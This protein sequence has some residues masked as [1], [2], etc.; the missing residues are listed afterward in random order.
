MNIIKHIQLYILIFTAFVIPLEVCFSQDTLS[1]PE[2]SASRG[3]YDTAFELVITSDNEDASIIYTLDGSNPLTSQSAYTLSSPAVIDIDPEDET[4]RY[5]APVVIVRACVSMDGYESSGVVTHSYFFLDDIT[6]LSPHEEPPGDQ[7]PDRNM[8]DGEFQFMDYGLDPDVY[9]DP[10]YEDYIQEAFTSVP[11]ISLV[12][13]LENLF[14]PESGI[15]VNA[16][17]RGIDWER[18]VSVELLNPDD[19]P[20]FQIDAGLRMRG[21]WGRRNENPKHAFRLFFRQEYGSGKLNYPL[22]GD[23]GV[24]EFDNVDLRTSQ[25]YSWAAEGSNRNTMVR[26]LFSRDTQRDMEQ[27]YTRTRYYHLYINGVY[28]GLYQTQER[29][30]ASYAASYFGGSSDEYD[31]IKVDVGENTD[32]YEIEATDGNLDAYEQLWEYAS[33]GFDTDEAYYRVLGQNSDGTINPDYEVLVDVDNLADYMICT[34]YVGDGDGPVNGRQWPNNFYGIYNHSNPDG[35]KYFRHDAEHSLFDRNADITVACTGGEEFRHFNPR[36]LHQQLAEHPEYRIRFADRVYKHFFYDGA[37]TPDISIHRLDERISSIEEAI[38]ALS[39][40]W[41]DS[42]SDTPRTRNVD[43]VN[44]L[45]F[46]IEDIFPYR[47]N[48]VLNQFE[49]RG[50]FPR[51]DPPEF[52]RESGIVSPGTELSLESQVGTI[53]CTVDGNDPRLPELADESGRLSPSAIEYN[54]PLEI[55]STM[56]IKARVLSDGNWSALNQV[57]LWVPLGYDNLLITEIHYHPSDRQD[58]NDT[59]LEFIELKNVGDVSLDIGGLTFSEGVDFTFET[60]TQI[61][62]DEYIVLASNPDEFENR[63]AF[64][65]FDEY[66]SQ[67]NN[68]GDTISL[69]YANGDTLLNIIYQDQF[70]WPN[71]ADGDGY[72]LV[73]REESVT[74]DPN[75]PSSWQASASRHGSPG[76]LD[77]EVPLN[78]NSKA[79]PDAFQL[80]Q[81]YPNPFNPATTIHFDVPIQASVEVVIY[82]ILGQKIR[83]LEKAIMSAGSHTMHW[84]GKNDSGMNVTS[85]IYFYRV[86]FENQVLVKKM[87]LLK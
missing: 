38:I 4:G 3:F 11:S 41:G 43:W 29:S 62:A 24:D 84:D 68:G 56:L 23:E 58:V 1:V 49:N 73:L 27:P 37:C 78:K 50:W 54:S 81:N 79:S 30:E 72:S 61:D 28:W 14:D 40:R 20:G 5:T 47:T 6:G 86:K 52:N 12:T 31:V 85:G 59:E 7:W 13:D 65:P 21:G 60:G 82:N 55:N 69:H 42:S 63:Y 66:N 8:D 2:F 9:E 18:Q 16:R 25:N 67:L 45:D 51:F 35:F 33:D 77:T 75:D 10:D 83:L 71:S 22:F 15:Y 26:A 64:E 36:W 44:A 34:Y 87:F 53:Y 46:M 17:R 48:A 57:S 74:L 32:L 70:P 19:S 76:S 80:Y 39:A